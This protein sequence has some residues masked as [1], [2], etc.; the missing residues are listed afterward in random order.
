MSGTWNCARRFSLPTSLL[1][2]S[3][4][5]ASASAEAGAPGVRLA[6]DRVAT[7]GGVVAL[8]LGAGE[9]LSAVV[10]DADGWI[11]A[12]VQTAAAGAGGAGNERARLSLWRGERGAVAVL[13]VPA[14]GGAWLGAP[15]V[16]LE[17][18]GGARPYGL[19][20]LEGADRE[21]AAVRWAA[22]DGAGWGEPATL[23]PAGPGAQLG[24]AATRLADGRVLLAWSR[25]DG[26]DDEIYWSVG[27]RGGFS[28][29]ARLEA[30]DRVPDH[31]PAVAAV[32]GGA[33]VAWSAYDESSRQY[34]VLAARFDGEAWSAPQAL[35]PPGS[36]YPS[37][38]APAADGRALLLYRRA[39]P[40]GWEV[41]ETDAAGRALRRAGAASAGPASERPAAAV[42]GGEPVLLFAARRTALAWHHLEMAP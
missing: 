33:L 12:G 16:V 17:P 36:L 31:T 26:E 19:A 2:L 14:T 10:G 7:A 9:R 41:V 24:L 30:D 32:A 20:W 22:W 8:P 11:A 13:P 25:H 1:L 38:E 40:G 28:A 35:G 42:L 27:G 21:R 23:S 37:F 6:S 4:A 39:A 5:A 3:L 15:A 18:G 29:P 34:R